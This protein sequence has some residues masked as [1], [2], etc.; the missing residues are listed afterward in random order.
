MLITYLPHSGFLVETAG[1]YYIFD[2]W[3]GTLPRLD[4]AKPVTVFASHAHMDHYEPKIFTLLREQGMEHVY[5]VLGKD[6]PR[7]DYPEGIEC[8]RVLAHKTYPLPFGGEVYTLQSTD[9]GV[10]FLLTSEEGIVYHAGDLNDWQWDGE[11]NENNEAM[12][13]FYL[14]ELERI[15]DRHVDVAFLPLDARQEELCYLGMAEFLDTVADVKAAYPMHYWGKTGLIREFTRRYPQYRSVVRNP[16]HLRSL[17][18]WDHLEQYKEGNRLEAKK[19]QGG[20]PE[21][22]WE[23]YSAFANTDGGLILLGVI[24]NADK[25]FSS[26]EL[27]DPHQLA[28]DFWN[29]LNRPG[30]V[31]ANILVPEDVRVVEA[32][33]HQIVVFCVPPA[34][35]GKKPVYVGSDRLSGS[36]CRRGEGD[37]RCTPEEIQEMRQKKPL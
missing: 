14:R 18:D 20:L 36:Y 27:P 15:A 10:A 13:R 12:H 9:A 29:T 24:E 3:K 19:A 8:L 11:P 4:P 25:S 33:G 16:E 32:G 6:I 35:N 7:E 17:L 5:A 37:Y 22:I 1:N 2:Y 21:S 26:V 28:A 30:T 34:P 31:S 23:T